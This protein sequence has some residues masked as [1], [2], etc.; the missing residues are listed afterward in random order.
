MSSTGS[1]VDELAGGDDGRLLD[2]LFEVIGEQLDALQRTREMIASIW[3][4][5]CVDVDG[6]ITGIP[7]ADLTVPVETMLA[8]RDKVR[9]DLVRQVHALRI[10]ARVNRK[11][12]DRVVAARLEERARRK[13][14]MAS[15]LANPMDESDDGGLEDEA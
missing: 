12:G 5:V 3:G 15:A 11:M 10:T 13:E 4:A 9:E 2:A 7:S 14:L 6:A 1:A 8:V